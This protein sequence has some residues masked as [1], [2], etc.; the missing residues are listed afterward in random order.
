MDIIRFYTDNNIPHD[1]EGKNVGAGW[2]N[3]QCPYCNDL[4]N[5]LGFSLTGDFFKCWRCGWHPF[6]ETLVK[7]SG[8]SYAQVEDTLHLY[9]GKT[10]HHSSAPVTREERRPNKLPSGAE[11]LK[12]AHKQ[13]LTRRGFDPDQL[14]QRWGLLGTGPVSSL[15]ETDYK[16]RI[17]IP[18]YWEG[19]RVSFTSR[20]ITNKSPQ[21]Y[22]ACPRERESVHHKDILYGKQHKWSNTGIWAEGPTDVWRLGVNAFATFGTEVTPRQVHQIAKHFQRVVILFDNEPAAQTQANKLAAEVRLHGVKAEISVVKNDPG[23]M[24]QDDADHLVRE[25]IR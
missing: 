25:I 13:Y 3:V 4:S 10:P 18:I 6:K 16:H 19:H 7:L 11:P 5:H 1:T 22:K 9:G 23:A 8:L 17:I 20:D 24:K 15:D 12:N 2:V 14:E 21:R